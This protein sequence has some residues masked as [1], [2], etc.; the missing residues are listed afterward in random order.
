MITRCVCLTIDAVLLT[1]STTH[2]PATDLGFLLHKN[3][4]RLQSFTLPFGRADVFYP[5]AERDRCTVAL[6]LGIDP[7]GLVRPKPGAPTSGGW[8]EQY[9]NDHPY[10]ASSHLSVAIASVFGSA[11]A[12]QMR[13]HAGVIDFAA[14]L[15]AEVARS[16][17][18]DLF[19]LLPTSRSSIGYRYDWT[20][21]VIHPDAS[22]TLEYKGRWR[23]Y[24]LE[25]ERR[26]TT[27]KRARSRLKSYR[28]Y[29]EGGWAERDHEGRPPRVLFVFEFPD[30]ENTFLDVADTVK[31]APII[32]SN[33][34]TLAER[35]ILGDAWVLPP[36]HSLDRRPLSLMHQRTE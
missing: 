18:H 20:T 31:G 25:F 27:P 2:Q 4:G 13:H 24:L 17:D 3:P 12:S 8:L 19:D 34:E 29:F 26:A 6:L 23:P 33:I 5:E 28:R 36:P 9:V 11:L 21:Y 14:G 16:P 10:V 7:V 15:S 32:T 22:L 30:N 35:G 1:I